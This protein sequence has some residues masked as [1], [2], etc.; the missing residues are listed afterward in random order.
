MSLPLEDY[1]LIGDT[2]TAALVARDGSIDWLCLPRFDSPACF[3]ALL[4]E[5]RHGRWLIAPRPATCAGA[6]PPLPRRHARA[7]RPSSTT[8]AGAVRLIDCMPPRERA[9]DLV[10]VVEG[11]AARSTMRMELVIRFDYGSIVPWVRQR[12]R[13]AGGAIAGP[14]AVALWTHG[15][16]ARR[17]SARRWPSSSC[18]RGRAR[19]VRA[20]VAPVARAAAERA[21]RRRRRSRRPSAWWREW[22]GQC[23]YEGEWRDAVL[24]SLITLKALTY[25]PTGGIVAARDHVAARADRR[26]AQLGLP[27]LLAARRDVHALRAD[28]LRATRDEAA[29]LARLAAARGRR[30]PGRQLQIMYGLS[31][32]RRLTELELPWLP[33]YEGSRPVRI[34]NAA[35]DQ[36][37]LDVYGEVMDALYQAL[38][39]GARARR[40]RP[41]RAARC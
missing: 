15:A 40:R 35:V 24:R 18:R 28:R 9:P 11:V 16:A 13:R 12:R 19:A 1:A 8:A 26:R 20:D 25:A 32:E 3:A 17:G 36:L 6:A 21:R 10:R 37:Q 39:A 7:S 23:T 4:G 2:Q 5:P 14:D 22:C 30:R 29:G 27:L 34:G 31:G 33:G 41:G 38:R